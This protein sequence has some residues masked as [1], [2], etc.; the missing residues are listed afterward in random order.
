MRDSIFSR[1]IRTA[2]HR[3]PSLRSQ[4]GLTLTEVLVVAIILAILIIASMINAPK[5]IA[6]AN[7]SRR[8]SDLEAFKIAFERYY[9]D[10]KCYPDP[11]VMTTCRTTVLSTYLPYIMCDP[12]LEMPYEYVRE[13]CKSFKIY[14]TL[15]D[16]SDPDIE[17]IGCTGGCGPDKNGDSVSDFNYGVSSGDVNVG[18]PANA[19]LPGLCILGNGR[20]CY[21]GVCSACCPG[22][23]YRCDMQGVN[24][25]P[26]TLCTKQ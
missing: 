18:A 25:V 9:D 4:R 5:F 12:K 13:S 23:A 17:K 15:E 21:A 2:I 16:T 3:F 26:D 1:I 24:C 6:R 19:T 14:T 20:K 11:S 22:D 7:D 10:Y 8:K